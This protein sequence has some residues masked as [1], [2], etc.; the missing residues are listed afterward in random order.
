M[1]TFLS[2]LGRLFVA[3]AV[4]IAVG[5][6]LGFTSLS[7]ILVASHHNAGSG[8]SC[9]V[10]S[11]GVGQQLV[12]SGRGFAANTQYLLFTTSP[13]GNGE[14]TANTDSTGAFSVSSV[15][16]WHGTYG[17]SVWS[18]GGGSRQLAACASVTV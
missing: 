13:G 16:Y 11:S 7:G 18:S 3:G 10:S 12:F 8:G 5:T 9:A 14:T 6:I 1:F 17:A 15:A 2:R 4:L